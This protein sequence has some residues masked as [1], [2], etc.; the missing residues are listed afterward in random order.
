MG[1]SPTRVLRAFVEH[2]K[3]KVNLKL[4]HPNSK[5]MRECLTKAVKSVVLSNFQNILH[6]ISSLAQSHACTLSRWK[7]CTYII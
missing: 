5:D 2:V 3:Y 6:Q 7:T 4:L 1:N